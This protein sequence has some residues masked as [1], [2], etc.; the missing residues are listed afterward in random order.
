M[1]QP[2]TV[3]DGRKSTLSGHKGSSHSASTEDSE[4]ARSDTAAQA[5]TAIEV[6]RVMPAMTIRNIC[7]HPACFWFFAAS[8]SSVVYAGGPMLGLRP[9]VEK[10]GELLVVILGFCCWAEDSKRKAIWDAR[11]GSDKLK[12]QQQCQQKRKRKDKQQAVYELEIPLEHWNETVIFK[13]TGG[14]SHLL[15]T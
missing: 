11:Q 7:S 9:R 2:R 3:C 15:W 10:V 14:P 12:V 13:T 8:K 5:M 1:P 6:A 4:Y